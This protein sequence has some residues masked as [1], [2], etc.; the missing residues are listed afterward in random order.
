MAV[1]IHDVEQNTAAW[2]ALR[3]GIPTASECSR[4]VTPT[5]R[6][7]AQRD[8]YI[9][10]LLAEWIM[11]EPNDEFR[12]TAWTDRGSYIEPEARR[13]YAFDADCEVR[14]VGFV[15]R[16]ESRMVGGSPDGLV[17]D[18]GLLECKAP[19]PH[20]HILWLSRG[21]V[22]PE[23]MPQLQF[24]LWLTGRATIDFCSFAPEIIGCMGFRVRVEPDP[25]FQAALDEHIPA[26]VEEL[27]AAR[28]R[29]RDMGVTPAGE[30]PADPIPF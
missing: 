15:Y 29:L 6:L 5:G 24:L 7:S 11:G 1:Y 23:H 2:K 26:F 8:K 28:D 10:E 17:G 30:E 16:D 4:I 13:W 12:G 20:T 27:L 19:A 22:P 21:V 25:K 18:D 14:E 3:L 9:G